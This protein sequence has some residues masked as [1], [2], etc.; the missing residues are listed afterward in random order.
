MA[1]LLVF[2]IYMICAFVF[3]GFAGYAAPSEQIIAYAI[4]LICLFL[5]VFKNS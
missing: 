1:K 4:V 2:I 3:I 5:I